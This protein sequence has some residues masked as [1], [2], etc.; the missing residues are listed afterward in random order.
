M[1]KKL[2][3]RTFYSNP[4]LSATKLPNIFSQNSTLLIRYVKLHNESQIMVKQYVHFIT[5]H[6]KAVLF[7][8]AVVTAFFG[9]YAQY[10]SIDASAE[11]L[12]LENDHD[13]KLT[14]EVHGRYVSP[15]Y[16]VIAYSP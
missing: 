11:T 10:L 9:Y 4:S 12:L 2:F 6:F 7:A 8:I 14:R 16:L 15:D 1:K 13:L 5:Q 3:V